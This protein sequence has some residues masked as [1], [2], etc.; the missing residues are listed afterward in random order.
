LDVNEARHKTEAEALEFA[1]K[2]VPY[3]SVVQIA[4]D[5]RPKY[6][7]D[8]KRPWLVIYG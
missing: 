4:Y 1:A 5:N 6:L 2:R 7:L 3:Y 8:W